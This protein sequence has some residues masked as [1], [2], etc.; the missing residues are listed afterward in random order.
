M[1]FHCKSHI[2]PSTEKYIERF[3]SQVDGYHVYL[4]DQPVLPY[5][6]IDLVASAQIGIALYDHKPRD[7]NA[8]TVGLSSG[9]IAHYLQCGLPVIVSN[10]P[11][12]K[13]LIDTYNCGIYVE[14]VEEVPVAVETILS[15]YVT[16]SKNAIICFQKEFDFDLHMAP[17]LARLNDNCPCQHVTGLNRSNSTRWW[18]GANWSK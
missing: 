17:I 1:V 9:K 5:Q 6:I 15:D 12:L 14:K 3:I 11:S 10:L 7:L 13:R 16:Y 2:S 8:Y 18:A 4:S